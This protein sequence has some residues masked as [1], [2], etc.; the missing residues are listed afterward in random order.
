MKARSWLMMTL[1]LV[2]LGHLACGRSG[3]FGPAGSDKGLAVCDILKNPDSY[4]GKVIRVKANYRVG[5]EWAYLSCSSC[6]EDKRIGVD[7]GQLNKEDA[8]KLN[9]ALERDSPFKDVISN[10]V[11]VGTFKTGGPH[12][13][14]FDDYLLELHSVE[15][16]DVIYNDY[17]NSAKPAPELERAKAKAEEF[18]RN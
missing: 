8:E 13:P 16:I 17:I 9:K 4:S 7:L 10:V 12:A 11:F 5:F 14:L 18:C 6:S 2:A 1:L 15:S 3:I